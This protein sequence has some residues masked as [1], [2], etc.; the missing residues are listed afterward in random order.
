MDTIRTESFSHIKVKNALNIFQTGS[1]IPK[2]HQ[3]ITVLEKKYGKDLPLKNNGVPSFAFSAN[4]VID[5]NA[6]GN[7]ED[8]EPF[9]LRTYDYPKT[10]QFDGYSGTSSCTMVEAMAATSCQPP[11]LD[12]V[13]IEVDGETKNLCDGVVLCTCPLPIAIGEAMKLYPTRPLGVILSLGF[14][15]DES[16]LIYRTLETTRLVHPQLHFQRIAPTKIMES[17]SVIESDIDDIA[18]MEQ[19]VKDYVRNTPRVKNALKVTIEKLFEEDK[20]RNLTSQDL[21]LQTQSSMSQ[22]KNCLRQSVALSSFNPYENARE[23]VTK[24][25]K[26]RRNFYA[27]YKG[28]SSVERLDLKN[29]FVKTKSTRFSPID[30]SH[31]NSSSLKRR[32]FKS[33]YKTDAG[34]DD[35]KYSFSSIDES[36]N[37]EE[38]TSKGKSRKFKF[39]YFLLGAFIVS[40]AL[41]ILRL[42]FG[43]DYIYPEGYDKVDLIGKM[44][45]AVVV[46]TIFPSLQNNARLSKLMMNITGG[47]VGLVIHL[48][49]YSLLSE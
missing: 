45:L 49:V 26:S 30:K 24:F 11:A 47:I 12:R 3:I 8:I 41:L 5:P 46:L 37:E 6:T 28:H 36:E 42:L 19:Q 23:Q 32:L 10:N 20:D 39:Y 14:M 48:T 44:A 25:L 38:D 21:T 17:F 16:D 34:N 15:S 22:L 13:K 29:R 27:N 9:I 40:F 43:V 2:E 7:K 4:K 31:K 1:L 35:T 18:I 33:V